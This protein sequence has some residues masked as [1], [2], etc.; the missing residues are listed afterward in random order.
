MAQTR[1]EARQ[2][3]WGGRSSPTGYALRG[4]L[5]SLLRIV[6]VILL[7]AFSVGIRCAFAQETE[8]QGGAP[9]NAPQSLQEKMG[10]LQEV[11]G[12]LQEQGTDIQPVGQLMQGLGPLIQQQKFAEAKALLDRAIKLAGELKVSPG[13][14]A[15]GQ[16]SG[17]QRPRAVFPQNQVWGLL[18]ATIIDQKTGRGVGAR[19]YL[20]DSADRPWSPSG[21]IYKYTP[22]P[23]PTLTSTNWKS[24]G[25]AGYVKKV[26]ASGQVQNLNGRVGEEAR[27]RPDHLS[28][29]RTGRADFPH[30]ALQK[31][32]N[33][34]PTQAARTA[35]GG[36]TVVPGGRIG[37]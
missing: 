14:T 19:C 27:P 4:D 34:R 13:R 32:Y 16:P 7:M 25:K 21:A 26:E 18:R 37:P 17:I 35:K 30:P 15:P 31:A 23:S 24:F 5:F 22:R 33:R 8:H 29:R 10:R 2:M 9:G 6:L 3:G 12:R 11:L 36:A 28:P 1:D 20:T